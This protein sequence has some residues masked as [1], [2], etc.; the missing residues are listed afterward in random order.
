M[1]YFAK[2]SQNIFLML[3]R[4]MNILLIEVSVIVVPLKADI[5]RGDA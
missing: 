5:D 4:A 2:V 1:K 3:S